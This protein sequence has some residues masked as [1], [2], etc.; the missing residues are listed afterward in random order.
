MK[1]YGLSGQGPNRRNDMAQAADEG[2]II[3]AVQDLARGQSITLHNLVPEIK[4]SIAFRAL[5]SFSAIT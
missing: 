4:V 2:H 1:V 5:N 3:P